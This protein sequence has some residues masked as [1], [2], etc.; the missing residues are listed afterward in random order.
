MLEP[1]LLIDHE[2]TRRAQENGQQKLPVFARL[3]K[4]GKAALRH[5]AARGLH[6]SLLTVG[7]TR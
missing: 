4:M 2:P 1:A 7:L 5:R 3:T 6:L